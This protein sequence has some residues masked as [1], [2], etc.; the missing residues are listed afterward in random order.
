[1]ATSSGYKSATFSETDAVQAL[2]VNA[3]NNQSGGTGTTL[4]TALTVLATNNGNAANNVTVTFSDGGAGGTFSNPTVTTTSSGLASTTYTLPPTAQTVTITATSSA[5]TSATFTETS[6][7][8]QTLSVSSGNN[9]TGTVGTPLPAPLTVLATSNGTPVSGVTVA[10]SDNGAGGSFGS[11]TAT[12]GSNGQASST[13]TPGTTGT[14]SITASSSGYS[15]AS[16]TET[17]TS[18]VS[19]ASLKLVAGSRQTGTVGTTLP[20]AIEIKA[21][22]SAGKIVSGASISFTDGGVG[23]SFSPN[24]AITNSSGEAST[25]YTLPTTPKSITVVASVGTVSVNATEKSVDG[26]PTDFTIVSGNNQAANPGKPL[27]KKLIVLL[28]DQYGNPLAGDTVDFTD[29]GA[30][31]TFS[32]KSPVTSSSGEASVTYTTGSK[33]GTVTITAT[34]SSLPPLEFTETVK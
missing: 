31:G 17:V 16:F 2:T 13:Y 9:Q 32:N 21:E 1:T 20:T 7:A 10:F 4:P 3:G 22:N 5:Y 27:T 26:P 11:P 25:S 8:S 19:V 28:T 14:I 23:G 6:T 30:G 34:T 18:G 33:T 12:T 15:S 29:D 24:P